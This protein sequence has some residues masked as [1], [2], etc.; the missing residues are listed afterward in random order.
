MIVT[1][2]KINICTLC[3]TVYTSPIAVIKDRLC[4]VDFVASVCFWPC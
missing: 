4:I 2:I 3:S 1:I